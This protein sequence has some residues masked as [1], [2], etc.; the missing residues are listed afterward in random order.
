METIIKK[1]I[2]F[3]IKFDNFLERIKLNKDYQDIDTVKQYLKEANEIGKPKAMYREVYINDRGDDYIIAEDQ[4]FESKI[5]RVNLEDVYKV[6]LYVITCGQ[7]LEKWAK[8][9][10]ADMLEGYWLS[11]LQEAVLEQA[12]EYVMNEIEKKYIPGLSSRMNPG[13][14]VDW[15]ITEQEKLF[16]LLGNPKK[17]I[18]VHLTDSSLMVP[19]KSVSGLVYPAE[20]DF[21]NCQVCP[22]E[23]CPNRS[24]PYQPELLEEK[25]Q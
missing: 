15:S 14:L 17:E 20:K 13:S 22:R 6:L 24:A 7:E 23:D 4:K 16:K 25:Y 3:E 8:E 18:G 9:K 11:M 10:E 21:E 1:D 19:T 2:P 12:L 5:M